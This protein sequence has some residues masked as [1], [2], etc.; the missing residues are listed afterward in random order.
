MNKKTLAAI[1]AV[2]IATS[3]GTG[4]GYQTFYE[5]SN[6]DAS[7]RDSNVIIENSNVTFGENVTITNPPSI[8]PTEKSENENKPAETEELPYDFVVYEWHLKT[9]YINNVTWLNN[10]RGKLWNVNLSRNVPLY[11]A[12]QTWLENYFGFLSDRKWYISDKALTPPVDVF[13]SAEF[14]AET[15]WTKVVYEYKETNHPDYW[16]G[17]VIEGWLNRNVTVSGWTKTLI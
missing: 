9:E 7:I 13:I 17:Y 15:G 5:L 12:S 4:I 11:N 8:P 14:N 1:I 16:N 3:I 6:V 10:T 2:I